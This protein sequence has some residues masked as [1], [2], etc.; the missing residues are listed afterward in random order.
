[1]LLEGLTLVSD[2]YTIFSN[3]GFSQNIRP[4]DDTFAPRIFL[5]MFT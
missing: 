4:L 2:V 1:M 5:M 3:F